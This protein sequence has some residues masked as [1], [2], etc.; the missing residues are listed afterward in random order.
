MSAPTATADPSRRHA[1]TAPTNPLPGARHTQGL[2]AAPHEWE[3]QV[4]AFL[5]G[6]LR[7]R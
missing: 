2:R 7:P 6:S 3:R 1:F 4:V 5:D